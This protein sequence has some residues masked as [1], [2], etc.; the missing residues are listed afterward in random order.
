MDMMGHEM[1]PFLMGFLGDDF[2][3]TLE[4]RMIIHMICTASNLPV[5]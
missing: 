2:L 4:S 5:L 1:T 3:T